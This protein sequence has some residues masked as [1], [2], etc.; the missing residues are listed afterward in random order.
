MRYLAS[1]RKGVIVQGGQIMQDEN[2]PYGWRQ[3]VR[4]FI[5]AY[6]CP[7]AFAALIIFTVLWMIYG[8]NH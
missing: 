4:W 7:I 6:K 1:P 8:L 2:F 3:E 5:E